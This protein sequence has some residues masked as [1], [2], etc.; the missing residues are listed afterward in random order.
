MRHGP[1]PPHAPAQGA[2]RVLPVRVLRRS[3]LAGL[4]A[5][6][7]SVWI[8]SGAAPLVHALATA[9]LSSMDAG[10]HRSLA[11]PSS[12]HELGWWNRRCGVRAAQA[13]RADE[14]EYG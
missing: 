7:S 12:A 4:L 11:A 3:E 9:A 13:T 14:K 6:C 10:I 8:P 1:R 2:R 5:M